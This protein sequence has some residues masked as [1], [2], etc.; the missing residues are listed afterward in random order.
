MLFQTMQK[1]FLSISPDRILTRPID[2]FAYASD[3]SFYRLIPQA[4]VQPDSISDIQSLF[5]FSHDQKIPLTF[6]AAGTSLSGQAITDGILVDLSKHWG[7]IQ[8][9]DQ[10]NLI[11]VQPGVIG[12]HANASLRSSGRRIGPDPASIDAC[13]LG[14]ILANNASGM[15]CG[16][17][18]NAY[19]TLQSM[20]LMLPNGLLLDTSSKNATELLISAAPD[21]TRGLLELRRRLKADEVLSEKVH[22]RY[23]RKNTTGYS[24]N[25]LLDY[26]Q[27]VDILSHILIG[28][29][30]TLG[31]IAEAVL[32]T[33]PEYQYKLTGLLYFDNVRSAANAIEP[34]TASGAR[35][36]EIMD[37]AALRSVESLPGSPSE[38]AQ[39]PENVAA[40]LVE[41]Q[42]SSLSEITAFRQIAE[43][44]CSGLK[45]IGSPSFTD[46]P[47]KQAALWKL[48][49]GMF[50]SIGASRPP[51][52]TVIIEDIAFKVSQL[53]DAITDLQNLFKTHGYSEGIIFGHAKD[54]NLHFVIAQSFNDES[55]V[56][57]YNRFMIDLVHLVTGKYNGALKAEHGTGRNM[58]PFVEQEWGTP[59][60]KI[61][62]DLKSLLDPTGLLNPGVIINSDPAAHLQ[63][64]KTLPVIESEVDRC[65]ECGF[66]ESK[67]PSRR[68]TLTP[69]QRI[70]LRR[71]I[72]R[73]VECPTNPE[74]LASLKQDYI[75]SGLD[76]CAVDGLCATACPVNINTGD[77]VKK[78]RTLRIDPRGQQAAQFLGKHFQAVENV[79]GLGV[80]IGHVA[81]GVIGA[82]RIR[83]VTHS[84][85]KITGLQLPKWNASVPHPTH[86]IPATAHQYADY[87][88]FPSCLTRAM[89]CPPGDAKSPSLID[90][91]LL[92]SEHAGVNVWIPESSK[93]HCCGMPFGS[94]GYDKAYREMLHSTIS[95]LWRWSDQGRLPIVM[96]ASSCAYTLRT[97]AEALSPEDQGWWQRMTILDPIEFAHDVLL[98]R[99]NIQ[100]LPLNVVLHPNCASRKLDLQNKLVTIAQR[101]AASV[102][103]PTN[104]DCCGFAGDRGLLFPELTAS[105][106]S[107]EAAEINASQYDGY[108]SS[109]LTCEMGMSEAT[110]RPYRSIFYLLARTF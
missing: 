61:M 76:T 18:E 78:L 92:V 87:V 99:L 2:R 84:V 81:E 56:N 89:G 67:C 16:V 37:R 25:A 4:V 39:L 22:Q 57:R 5:Q 95:A 17:A 85:E 86:A 73:Q 26:S 32:R 52:T 91:V 46:E 104:L 44:T 98:P 63:N 8:V 23:Q 101:C 59:A 36:L 108:Y 40:L 79:V 97:C 109:N 21:V 71:E 93:G 50:P 10:G 75:Y 13:M 62:Q 66:C 29:E 74:I 100:P 96:D 69:R 41:Y 107:V 58:A 28:S 65:I 30:G 70:V 7:K 54:G 15:C 60:Y 35:A 83:A 103:I 19:H 1:P 3:A 33:L 94:K 34:L 38:L 110:G 45:T 11:R 88:Y 90:V 80:R 12:A 102:T 9:E 51:G 14:G 68:L 47:L 64:L 43:V 48:R 24:L 49:K 53:A 106:T 6:R 20:T 31:F 105:A 27:P 77:L 42:A 82:N 55:E 72:S